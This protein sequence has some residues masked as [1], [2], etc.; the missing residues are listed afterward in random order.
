M[1]TKLKFIIPSLL[2]ILLTVFVIYYI[3]GWKSPSDIVSIEI[4]A[5]A[6]YF[7]VHYKYFIDFSEN[8]LTYN[9]LKN[10]LKRVTTFSDEDKKDFVH[11]ANMYGFF[12][13]KES[14]SCP[15]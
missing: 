6:P 7:Q 13:W 5:E 15:I 8:T 9:N 11:K 14:Y 1:K 2:A 3:S 12:N 4:S 10:D